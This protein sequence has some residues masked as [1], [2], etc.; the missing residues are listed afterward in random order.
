MTAPAPRTRAFAHDGATL[1]WHDAGGNGRPVVF[2][3]GLGGDAGQAAEAFPAD[4]RFRRVTLDCRGHGGSAASGGPF[5]I[6]TYARD[7]AAL[8]EAEL[9]PPLVVGG[10]SMGAAVALRLA[11]QRPELVRGLALVRPAWL[12]TPAPDNLRPNAELGRLLA[13][14]PPA[15]ARAA[16]A[17]GATARRLADV[18]PDNLASLLGFCDRPDPQGAARLLIA[19]AADDPGVAEAELARIPAPTLVCGT[20]ADE[21][22]P[23][24]LARRIAGLMPRA[25]LVELPAKG[26]DRAAHFAALHAALAAFLAE[27]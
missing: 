9:T 18:A 14:L 19:I 24:A 25:R 6:A 26:S 10:I 11:V 13:D 3:H 27:V 7:L 2:Q 23:L 12:A 22:H 20:E 16:F 15:E 8:I 1:A 21:I 17:A 4:P 5:A